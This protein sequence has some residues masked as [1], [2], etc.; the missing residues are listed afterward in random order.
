MTHDDS[1]MQTVTTMG[2]SELIKRGSWVPNVPIPEDVVDDL[3]H[4]LYGLIEQKKWASRSMKDIVT[5]II[6][7]N[8]EGTDEPRFYSVDETGKKYR[9]VYA[10]M[11]RAV[12]TY[13]FNLLEAFKE[14]L[15]PYIQEAL[16]EAMKNAGKDPKI[17]KII[18]DALKPGE[19]VKNDESKNPSTTEYD[20]VRKR[21]RLGGDASKRANLTSGGL[22]R[23]G[24][25]GAV[26]DDTGKRG[27]PAAGVVPRRNDPGMDGPANIIEVEGGPYPNPSWL[28]EDYIPDDGGEYLGDTEEQEHSSS[29]K[30]GSPETDE[31]S[32]EVD[33]M[34]L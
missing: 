9:L 23:P 11:R 20:E 8:E 5:E 33:K 7:A 26:R 28:F 27:R 13:R 3:R 32:D 2:T 18:L 17:L 10:T 29:D 6:G 31:E 14:D 15:S 4:Y 16:V 12:H 24:H 19:K 30:L 34:A 21:L 1:A 22:G 25:E